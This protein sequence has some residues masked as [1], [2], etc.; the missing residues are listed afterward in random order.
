MLTGHIVGQDRAMHLSRVDLGSANVEVPQIGLAEGREVRLR[1]RA[2]DVSL[3]LRRP[4]GMSIRNM[5][6][7]RVLA[8]APEPTSAFAEVLLDIGRQHL[9]ARVTRAAVADLGLAEGQPVI[10]LLKAVSFDRQALPRSV[11]AIG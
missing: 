4:E 3:A 11:K 7:A 6:E 10:A 9:R 1:V 5:L 2:R 8:I